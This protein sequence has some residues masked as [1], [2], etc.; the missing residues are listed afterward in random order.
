MLNF[1][2]I[3]LDTIGIITIATISV[4][5]IALILIGIYGKNRIANTKSVTY[6]AIC[7]SLAFT[8]SFVKIEMAFGGSITI[9][10]MLPLIIYT[11]IFGWYN[12]IIIGVIYGLLQFLQ[13]AWFLTPVQFI[14]DYITAF[15]AV[16]IVGV[17]AARPITVKNFIMGAC[18]F[19]ALRFV[20]HLLAGIIFYSTPD[21]RAAVL[22][23]FGDTANLSAFVYSFLYNIIYML[24]EAL[25]GIAA[26][27]LILK[28]KQMAKTING[29]NV[30]N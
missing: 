12:G 14:L 27:W 16:A 2:S 20:S 29:I 11:L 23:I 13:A 24:P 30:T 22:P 3:E 5:V 19:Y 25:I 28:N 26:G 9:A 6:G 4:I 10:S 8:L 1:A 7:V 17:F 18:S 21:M 15:G